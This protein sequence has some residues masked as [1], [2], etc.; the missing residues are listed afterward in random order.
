MSEKPS[1]DLPELKFLTDIEKFFCYCRSW[2]DGAGADL[3][4]W[5]Q[6]PDGCFR[7]VMKTGETIEKKVPS[8]ISLDQ[9]SEKN[10]NEII[11]KFKDLGLADLKTEYHPSILTHYD[12]W[13]GIRDNTMVT[14]HWVMA[15]GG[16]HTA[17]QG[18]ELTKTVIDN[19]PEL[20]FAEE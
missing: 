15:A 5:W 19:C 7:K 18:Y 14:S 1:P 2:W 11:K 4:I 17:E 10:L 6:T 20:S 12:A 16:R 3:V 9:I 8:L 13:F